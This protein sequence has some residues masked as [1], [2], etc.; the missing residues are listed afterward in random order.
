MS[1]CRDAFWRSVV[2]GG[3]TGSSLAAAEIGAWL[4]PSG[5]V[6]LTL[7]PDGSLCRRNRP[8]EEPQP[9]QR[10][11][12][13]HADSIVAGTSYDGFLPRHRER[14]HRIP[15]R[16]DPQDFHIDRAAAADGHFGEVIASG[17]HTL[18]IFQRLAVDAVYRDWA[19]IGGRR[20]SDIEFLGPV[21]PGTTLIGTLRIEKNAADSRPVAGRCRRHALRPAMSSPRVELP[22]RS[23]L[24]PVSRFPRRSTG[25]LVDLPIA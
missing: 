11:G 3:P 4:A 24:E 7:T 16:W 6:R 2:K 8:E 19:V 12:P 13:G 17:V 10:S 22:R 14:D 9:P 1:G 25:D 18:A 20:L 23:A 15:S 5:R 21:R